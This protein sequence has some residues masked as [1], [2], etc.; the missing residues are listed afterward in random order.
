MTEEDDIKKLTIVPLKG[1]ATKYSQFIDSIRYIPLETPPNALLSGRIPK[2]TYAKNRYF[3]FDE[4]KV[5]E[6]KKSLNSIIVLSNL[7]IKLQN[8]TSKK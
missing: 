2:V 7:L 3:V 8:N 6:L 5:A 1:T 4:N